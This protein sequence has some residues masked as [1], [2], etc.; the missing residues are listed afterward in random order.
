M[1]IINYDIVQVVLRYLFHE[2]TNMKYI[3]PSRHFLVFLIVVNI[4]IKLDYFQTLIYFQA[5]SFLNFKFQ[6]KTNK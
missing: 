2:H 5:N 1:Y 4:L 6:N 3:Q